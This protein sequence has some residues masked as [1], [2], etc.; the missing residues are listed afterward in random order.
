MGWGCT[1][2]MALQ[3]ASQASLTSASDTVGGPVVL[4]AFP[5]L[6]TCMASGMRTL[7]ECRHCLKGQAHTS[8]RD[9]CGTA[10]LCIYNLYAS[11]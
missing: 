1:S 9:V 4:S 3:E 7:T 11:M 8:K 10:E 2:W 6:S 5:L